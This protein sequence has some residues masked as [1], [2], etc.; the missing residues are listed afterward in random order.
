LARA[1]GHVRAHLARRDR[2]RGTGRLVR[3]RYTTG[4]ELLCPEVVDSISW[5]LYCRIPLGHID[6]RRDYS[7]SRLVVYVHRNSLRSQ[8][9]GALGTEHVIVSVRVLLFLGRFMQRTMPQAGYAAS[10]TAYTSSAAYT[11]PGR[12]RTWN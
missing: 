6:D 7:R 10:A 9:S 1:V 2:T 11:D 12:R 5:Q 4:D 3:G 8:H